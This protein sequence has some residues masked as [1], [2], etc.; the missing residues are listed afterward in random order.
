MLVKSC[1]K[2]ESL[3]I[4]GSNYLYANTFDCSK[5]ADV[6]SLQDALSWK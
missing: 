2:I 4:Y 6:A 1:E 5:K 3:I